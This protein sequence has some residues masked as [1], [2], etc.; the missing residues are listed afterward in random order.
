MPY[1]PTGRPP[2]RPRSSTLRTVTVKLPEDLQFDATVEGQLTETTL[3]AV[4]REGLTARLQQTTLARA[5]RR[6]QCAAIRRVVWAE[7]AADARARAEAARVARAAQE[8]EAFRKAV[9]MILAE[10]RVCGY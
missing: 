10:A 6:V 9:A 8:G 2:G 4:L 1:K 7:D 3:T 5:T